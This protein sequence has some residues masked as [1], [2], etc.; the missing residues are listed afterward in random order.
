MPIGGT[1]DVDLL[2]FQESAIV[3]SACLLLFKSSWL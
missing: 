3:L 1:P 2:E